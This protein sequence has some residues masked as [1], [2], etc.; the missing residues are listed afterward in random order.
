MVFK[1]SAAT[2]FLGQERDPEEYLDYI[3]LD[4]SHAWVYDCLFVGAKQG[5]TTK[6]AH[7]FKK[8]QEINDDCFPNLKS[9][10]FEASGFA[11]N[12]T[13]TATGHRLRPSTVDL[14]F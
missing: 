13:T 10:C 8:N 5:S 9:H 2:D 12:T 3:L 6:R 7:T 11:H 14:S 1:T 4:V